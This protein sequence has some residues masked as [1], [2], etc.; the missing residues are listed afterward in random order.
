MAANTDASAVNVGVKFQSDTAGFITGIRFY[1]GTGNSGTHVGSLWSST[2]TL[3]AQATFS[4]ETA[5]GWQSVTFATQ[6]AISA[7][8]T[9]IASYLAPNG[10]YA[11]D[12]TY[13]NTGVDRAP[14]HALSSGASG[15]N[16][17]YAYGA[18]SAMPNNTFNATN[19]WVDVSFHP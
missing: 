3:L 13:F 7:N 12:Q 14:L 15:G 19:Y 5:T 9:Y 17:V 1:K 4:G 11:S 8:T 18:S 10:H 6:V 16:G 2:G